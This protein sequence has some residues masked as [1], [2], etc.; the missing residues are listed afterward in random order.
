MAAEEIERMQMKRLRPL[1]KPGVAM[2][3]VV[4]ASGILF[5]V[6]GHGARIG[7]SGKYASV[8]ALHGEERLN[9]AA[10]GQNPAM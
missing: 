9:E 6:K 8:E 4:E 7:I 1:V 5:G 3:E 2:L 10:F